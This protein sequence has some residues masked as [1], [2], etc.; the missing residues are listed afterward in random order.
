MAS[1]EFVEYVQTL[2]NAVETWWRKRVDDPNTGLITPYEQVEATIPELVRTLVT[3]FLLEYRE[4]EIAVCALEGIIARQQSV[5]DEQNA[6]IRRLALN[7]RDDL[8]VQ[9]E[10]PLS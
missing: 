3:P 1:K 8:S 2:E 4:V 6:T 5:I 9:L 7:H 10:L